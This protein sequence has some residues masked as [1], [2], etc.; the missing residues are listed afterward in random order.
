MASPKQFPLQHFVVNTSIII[1]DVVSDNSVGEILRKSCN[2]SD[3][4]SREVKIALC[5]ILRDL[6]A[7]KR[8]LFAFCVHSRN[9]SAPCLNCYKV[10]LSIVAVPPVWSQS[11]F[12]RSFRDKPET[13]CAKSL[14]LQFLRI[15]YCEP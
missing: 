15:C 6:R 12:T 13:V 4:P 10:I 2:S 1:P 14:F 11:V 8:I 7:P 3:S 5:A 9:S